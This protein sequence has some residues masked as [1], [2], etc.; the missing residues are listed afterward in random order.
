MARQGGVPG[1]G[2]GRDAQRGTDHFLVA[3][4]FGVDEKGRQFITFND[5]ADGSPASKL[6]NRL[7][8]DSGTGNWRQA[9]DIRQP[10]TLSAVVNQVQD[11]VFRK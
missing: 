2:G 3:T 9:S 6:S 10:Y 8:R 11:G 1:G 4:G 5:P 7:Y